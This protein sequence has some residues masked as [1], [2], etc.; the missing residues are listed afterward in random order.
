MVIRRVDLP[1]GL[2]LLVTTM[3]GAP[4]AAEHHA[5]AADR[6]PFRPPA[7]AS[8]S[9]SQTMTIAVSSSDGRGADRLD[10]LPQ[11]IVPEPDH[12]MVE[13][14][15]PDNRRPG[16]APITAALLQKI[17]ACRRRRSGDSQVKPARSPLRSAA[18]PSRRE[19]APCGRDARE[20]REIEE[21]IVLLGVKLGDDLAVR[22]ERRSRR[23]H[24]PVR[25][26]FPHRPSR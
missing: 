21:G 26:R 24:L 19:E 18:K 12:G 20:V 25:R 22:V 7:A 13:P 5:V 15:G 17:R 11:I 8:S 14:G 6:M 16:H 4:P 10:R 23:R 3:S 1:R 2:S 9:S